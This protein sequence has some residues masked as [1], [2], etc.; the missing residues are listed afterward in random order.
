MDTL[1]PTEAYKPTPRLPREAVAKVTEG[2]LPPALNAIPYTSILHN[3]PMP[4]YLRDILTSK[5]SVREA[6]Q[7]LRGIYV[8]PELTMAT[9]VERL[10]SLLWIEEYQLE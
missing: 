4:G 7:Q 6:L 9:Y 10:K 3:E 8:S 1:K 2:E 5:V